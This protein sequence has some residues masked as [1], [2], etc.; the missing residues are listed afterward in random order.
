MM[1]QDGFKQNMWYI[2]LGYIISVI[3]DSSELITYI[4]LSGKI[5]HLSNLRL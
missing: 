1:C 2:Q 4:V 3:G 5:H